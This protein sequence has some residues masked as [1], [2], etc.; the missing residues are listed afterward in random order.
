[1]RKMKNKHGTI[2]NVTEWWMTIN[3]W[4]YYITEQIDEDDSDIVFALVLGFED[5]M[6]DISRKEIMPYIRLKTQDLNEIAPATDWRWI[7]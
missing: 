2:L 1:M 4:E 6:G 7:D 5:E 3:N